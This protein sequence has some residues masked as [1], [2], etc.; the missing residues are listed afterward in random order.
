MARIQ[1]TDDARRARRARQ[2]ADYDKRA[3]KQILLKLNRN[4]DAD[5]LEHLDAQENRQG[6]IKRLIREDIARQA[7]GE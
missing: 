7:A 2:Q 3:T 6:Y 5:I 4:T 1:D